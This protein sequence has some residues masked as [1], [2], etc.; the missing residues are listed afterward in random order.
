MAQLLDIDL[1]EARITPD[2]LPD[3]VNKIVYH[4]EQ[5]HG[6][7]S[8]LLFYL[9]AQRANSENEVVMFTGDGPDETMGGQ[10]AHHKH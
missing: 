8:F 1:Y 10:G 4:C 2:M 3:I 6:D 5:P 9:L 7:F